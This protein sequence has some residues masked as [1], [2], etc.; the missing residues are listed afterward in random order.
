MIPRFQCEEFG[1]R[2]IDRAAAVRDDPTC[3]SRGPWLS[4]DAVRTYLEPLPASLIGGLSQ[5][6]SDLLERSESSS[7]L[8]EEAL[9][10]TRVT[11]VQSG[12]VTWSQR[13]KDKKV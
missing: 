10:S 8:M 11:F 1:D 3:D 4:F 12:H 6:I 9:E 5:Q 7:L 13:S 2:L